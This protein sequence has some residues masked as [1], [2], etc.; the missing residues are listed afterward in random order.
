MLKYLPTFT[1]N[2]TIS[3]LTIWIIFKY[4]RILVYFNLKCI[5]KNF[6]FVYEQIITFLLGFVTTCK[7]N[8]LILKLNF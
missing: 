6:K 5:F 4:I 8:F 7:I 1:H 3:Q 2:L